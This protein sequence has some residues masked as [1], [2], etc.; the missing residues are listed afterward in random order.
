MT[1]I[2][3]SFSKKNI[4]KIEKIAKKVNHFFH[5]SIKNLTPQEL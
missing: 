5:F 1:Y 4:E 2:N 3:H